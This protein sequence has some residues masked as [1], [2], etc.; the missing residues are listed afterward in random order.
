M[1]E[2]NQTFPGPT[3]REQSQSSPSGKNSRF[4]PTLFSESF[5]PPGSSGWRTKHSQPPELPQV[6]TPGIFPSSSSLGFHFL[7]GKKYSRLFPDFL[8]IQRGGKVAFPVGMSGT[9]SGVDP[10][11]LFHITSHHKSLDLMGFSSQDAA[12]R[13]YPEEKP[14]VGRSRK[15][16]LSQSQL[17]HRKKREKLH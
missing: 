8:G 7:E 10:W 16:N 5:P 14:P 13:I 6:T 9:E 1:E 4:P 3:C 12:A 15:S 11:E 2:E 17:F